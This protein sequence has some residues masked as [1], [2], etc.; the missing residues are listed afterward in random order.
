MMMINFYFIFNF[1]FNCRCNF[2]LHHMSTHPL[3]FDASGNSC[4]G[5]IESHRKMLEILQLRL[6]PPLQAQR[7]VIVEKVQ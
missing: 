4:V 6:Y 5:K 7:L 3:L 1:I 2:R